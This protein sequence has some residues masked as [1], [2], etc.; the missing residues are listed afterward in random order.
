MS[1]GVLVPQ[2]GIE[3]RHS[4]VRT[5]SSYPSDHQEVPWKVVFVLRPERDKG[6]AVGTPGKACLGADT[7]SAKA[8]WWV[9]NTR[10][11]WET[12]R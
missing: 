9:G 7:A 12:R 5:W 4:V 2:A 6:A 3:P 10:G 11:V 1:L 8:L